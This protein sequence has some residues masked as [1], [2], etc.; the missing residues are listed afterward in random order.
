MVA[1]G[2]GELAATKEKLKKRKN[3]Y[4]KR[5][6]LK[7]LIKGLAEKERARAGVKRKVIKDAD[8]SCLKRKR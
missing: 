5:A 4:G 8:L 1:F 2:K 7:M 3:P 6:K